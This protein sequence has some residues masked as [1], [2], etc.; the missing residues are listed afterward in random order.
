MQLITI[1]AITSGKLSLKHRA[2]MC[3]RGKFTRMADVPMW[4]TDAHSLNQLSLRMPR[5][6]HVPRSSLS[7]RFPSPDFADRSRF[8]WPMSQRVDVPSSSAACFSTALFANSTG[9][10]V[11]ENVNCWCACALLCQLYIVRES[12]TNLHS[13]APARAHAA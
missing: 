1:I 5:G 3:C 2:R 10:T 6:K 8:R 13:I 7:C 12:S 11:T 4:P 9:L